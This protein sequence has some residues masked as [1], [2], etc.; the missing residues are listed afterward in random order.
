MIL[1]KE[2]FVDKINAIKKARELVNKV[3]ELIKEAREFITNDE[4]TGASLIIS[5]EDDLVDTLQVM[6]EDKDT[7]WISWWIYECGF[8]D[9]H[10]IVY[11]DEENVIAV[12][13]SPEALYDFLMEEMKDVKEH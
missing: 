1:S 7:E 9:R 3:D 5:H 10:P 13:A 12:L 8:G 6:F 11:D 2:E 4:T